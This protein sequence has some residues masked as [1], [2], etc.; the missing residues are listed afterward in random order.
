MV[1]EEGQA[2]RNMMCGYLLS[3][4]CHDVIYYVICVVNFICIATYQ[5]AVLRLVCQ[6]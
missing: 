3:W 1:K 6:V 4:V 2:A 5:S